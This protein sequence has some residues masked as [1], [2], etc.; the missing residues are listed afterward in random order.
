VPTCT[1]ITVCG[2]CF[3]IKGIQ[4]SNWPAKSH[5]A[6]GCGVTPSAGNTSLKIVIGV[7]HTTKPTPKGE[8]PPGKFEGLR[9]CNAEWTRD[10]SFVNEVNSYPIHERLKIGYR[11]IRSRGHLV[12]V[13]PDQRK[14]TGL[15]RCYG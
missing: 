1:K 5:I 13:S 12:L 14:G 8:S 10:K 9:S 7:A 15:S 11:M 3:R 4:S 2:E 6:A